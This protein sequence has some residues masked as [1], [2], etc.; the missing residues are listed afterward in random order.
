MKGKEILCQRAGDQLQSCCH[1]IGPQTPFFANILVP[2]TRIKNQKA[3]F[4][5]QLNVFG[6]NR[7]FSL[8]WRGV[9]NRPMA[10]ALQLV[11]S[12]CVTA[13]IQE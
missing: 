1:S 9:M 6:K 8:D 2:V 5:D 12:P 11:P 7:S 4:G 13:P 3:V 10:A